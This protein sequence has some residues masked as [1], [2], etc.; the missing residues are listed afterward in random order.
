MQWLTERIRGLFISPKPPSSLLVRPTPPLTDAECEAF[1]FQLLDGVSMG[2]GSGD[3][4]RFFAALVDRADEARWISWLKHLDVRLE[5]GEVLPLPIA[6]QFVR[7]GEV[8]SGPIAQRALDIGTNAI[9]RA[10]K[11]SSASKA[12][13]LQSSNTANVTPLTE[14]EPAAIATSHASEVLETLEA[15][16]GTAQETAEPTIPLQIDGTESVEENPGEVEEPPATMSLGATAQALEAWIERGQTQADRQKYASALLAFDCAV[17]IDPSSRDAWMYRGDALA[18][19]KRTKEAIKAYERAIELDPKAATLWS[20]L[21]DVQYELKRYALA[22]QSWKQ[23]LDINDRDSQAWANQGIAQG[24]GLGNWAEAIV[25]W[26]KA[27]E[28]EPENP[29][30]WFRLGVGHG[31]LEH[32]EMAIAQWDQALVHNPN[33]KDALVNKSV[34]LQKLGRTEE[35]EAVNARIQD[36]EAG[37]VLP[38]AAVTEAAVSESNPQEDLAPETHAVEDAIDFFDKGIEQYEQQNFQAAQRFFQRAIDHHPDPIV[39]LRYQGLTWKELGQRQ[40]AIVCWDK[41]LMV[42]PDNAELLALKALTLQELEE[43]EAANAAWDRVVE[44]LPDNHDAWIQKGITLQ[45]L[46]RYEEAI[47]ANNRAME[48]P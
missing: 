20:R 29:D 19:L 37:M 14:A 3:I 39:V 4:Q 38:V 22:I 13:A 5:T 34:A 8:A 47:A 15:S 32:W 30:L 16:E 41:V 26:E 25:C 46:E 1:F 43:W 21:G 28:I 10:P 44:L 36:L 12:S 27:V 45:K 33:F 6:Q 7:F 42:E 40:D 35:A 2:W 9:A 11:A 18:E 31:A 17:A 24:L 23:A 48:R